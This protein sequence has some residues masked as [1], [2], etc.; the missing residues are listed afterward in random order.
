MKKI[1]FIVVAMLVSLICGDAQS[2]D[3]VNGYSI[4]LYITGVE[5]GTVVTFNQY[6]EPTSR[7]IDT[8]PINSGG[9]VRFTG[10]NLLAPGMYNFTV[11]TVLWQSMTI[12]FFISAETPQQF[13]LSFDL[14]K[15][16]SSLEVKGSP[17]NELFA[18]CMHYISS[19]QQRGQV[20][21]QQL[22]QTGQSNSDSAAAIMMQLQQFNRDIKTKWATVQARLPSSTLALFANIIRD[23]EAPQPDIPPLLLNRD[24]IMQAYYMNYYKEHFFD[25]IDFSDAR[26]LNMPVLVNLLNTYTTRILPRDKDVLIERFDFIINKAKA[27]RQVYEFIVRNRY[28]F[29]RSTTYPDLALVAAHIAEKYVVEDSL[30]WTDKAYVYRMA[31]VVRMAQLNPI[32]SKATDLK[33]RDPAGNNISIDDIQARYLVLLFYNPECE[34]CAV[35]T[36]ILWKTYQEYGKKGLQVLAIYVDQTPDEWVSYITEHNYTWLNAWDPSGSENIY[37]KYDIYAIPTIYLL[38]SNK[39]IL[40]KDILIEQL[41]Q[42]L[43]ELLGP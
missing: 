43:N 19:I 29:F 5:G 39:T 24:S 42:S 14:Q 9:N 25:N 3:P 26:I 18:E 15:G 34:L 28:D 17:E 41:N 33:L 12:D 6:V 8:L 1:I 27:N 16:M 31:E 11:P 4:D 30:Q 36:P 35:E 10:E 13:S 32:G 20:L 2:E 21:Q 23:P 37:E 40:F 22:Q 38:D 7:I